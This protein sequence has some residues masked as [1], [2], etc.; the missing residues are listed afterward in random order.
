MPRYTV[1][2]VNTLAKTAAEQLDPGSFAEFV[3]A[4]AR[5]GDHYSL[6]NRFLMWVQCPQVAEVAGF[7]AWRERGRKVRKGAH[8]LAILAP[9]TRKADEETGQK[10]SENGPNP[11]GQDTDAPRVLAACRVTYVFDIAQTEP[12]DPCEQCG[13]EPGQECAQHR[14]TTDR[15][16]GPAPSAAELETLLDNLTRN[17]DEENPL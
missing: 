14:P 13:P 11:A 10:A 17:A 3:A 9:I 16:A 4:A 2:D 7:R 1:A 5:V 6:R 8:G 12:L 15:A